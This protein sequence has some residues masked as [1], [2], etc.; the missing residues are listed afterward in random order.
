MRPIFAKRQVHYSTIAF[1][2][3]QFRDP[4]EKN[5]RSFALGNFLPAQIQ[6]QIREFER[7]QC[8][9]TLFY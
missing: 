3:W 9:C 4:R 2:N 8:K 6:A 7:F 1:A 5:K